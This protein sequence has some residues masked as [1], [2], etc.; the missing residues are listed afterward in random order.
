MNR[1]KNYNQVVNSISENSA[2][3]IAKTQ[4]CNV[5]MPVT[6]RLSEMMNDYPTIPLYEVYIEDV[7]EFRGQHLVFTVPTIIV[8]FEGKEV[9]RESR[10]INWENLD[11]LLSNIK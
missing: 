3:I 8:F 4:G 2:V 1:I 10:F 9:H 11:S 6:L 7:P 5:C